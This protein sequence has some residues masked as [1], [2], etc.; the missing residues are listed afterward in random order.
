MTIATL[1]ATWYRTGRIA[2]RLP[3]EQAHAYAKDR[4]TIFRSDYGYGYEVDPDEP[5]SLIIAV[6]DD[7]DEVV[8]SIGG[9]DVDFSISDHGNI[10]L[11][12]NDPYLVSVVAGMLGS[13]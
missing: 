3:A 2:Y 6:L 12:D 11:D 1:R 4:L 5:G 8:D 10:N 7:D 9:V 13:Q